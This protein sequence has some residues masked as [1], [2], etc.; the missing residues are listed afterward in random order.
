MARGAGPRN[1]PQTRAAMAARDGSAPI[2]LAGG[3]LR[4][5]R[6]VCGLFSG[7]EEAY[8]ALL[9][10]IADGL[11]QGQRAVHFVEPATRASHLE[12]LA[13]VGLDVERALDTGQLEVATWDVSYL[14]AGRFDRMGMV[15]F[16]QKTLAEG[17]S[18]GFAVTRLI[19]FMEWALQQV[20]G[21]EDVVAY[22]TD[23]D[24][25][26]RGRPDPVIC[27]YD[28]SRH[29]AG[30]V[31]QLQAAH[32]LA[33]VGRKLLPIAE[34]ATNPR[35]RI[36]D[37]ASQLFSRYGVGPTG[38]DALIDS[39]GV[40][41]ATFFRYFPS[42]NDLIVA[43]LGD[44]RTRW[45]NRVRRRAEEMAHGP[46]ETIPAFFD[47]V[48]EWLEAE[49][50]RGCPY[51][52]TAVELIDPDHPAQQVIDEY[53]SDVRRYLA[54]V[55]GST[56]KGSSTPVRE[57]ERLALQLQMLLAGAIALSVARRS[58]NPAREARDGAIRL[59]AGRFEATGW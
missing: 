51:L 40:A 15:L 13:S 55:L 35:E 39:A 17:R 21:V 18:R 2:R 1:A 34:A 41:K 11:Q 59:L 28:L 9:P 52:N 4:R 20:P 43:W 44:G 37:A 48:V 53:L 49:H 38:V 58:S 32:P 30:V 29:A 10:F 14:R 23:L 3:E 47:A 22:E 36:L 24:Q 26:L 33:V 6:H 5:M 50:Y 54:D 57:R 27:A 56:A 42:K 12:R 31:A 16:V 19:G 25:F 8:S 46:D 45:L 7:V